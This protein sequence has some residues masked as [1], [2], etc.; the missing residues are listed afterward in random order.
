MVPVRWPGPELMNLCGGG[1]DRAY[2]ILEGAVVSYPCTKGMCNEC[3][4]C[5]RC[6]GTSARRREEPECSNTESY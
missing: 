1:Y 5:P 6:A 2:I 3:L 4:K